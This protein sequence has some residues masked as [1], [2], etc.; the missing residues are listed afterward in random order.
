MSHL[1]EG[2]HIDKEGIARMNTLTAD[3]RKARIV[4]MPIYK[5]E[6]KDQLNGEIPW[7]Q[8]IIDT[9]TLCNADNEQEIMIQIF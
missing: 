5:S 4:Y 8:V 2:M 3:N 7:S 9:D 6:C 1:I